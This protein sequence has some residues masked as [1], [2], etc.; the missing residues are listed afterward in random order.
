MVNSTGG[1]LA[2]HE[3]FDHFIFQVSFEK[4]YQAN[5]DGMFKFAIAAHINLRISKQ[6]R[7]NGIIGTCKSLKD[8]S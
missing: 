8:N 7:I 3:L 1:M 6:M 4:F 5:E 2:M